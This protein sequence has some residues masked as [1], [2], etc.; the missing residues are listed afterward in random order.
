MPSEKDHLQKAERNS[1]F[2]EHL[3]A[4]CPEYLEWIVVA[5]FYT[6]LHY[7]DAFLATKGVHP[8]DHAMRDLQV[9]T[10]LRQHYPIYRALKNDSV[11]ARYDTLSFNDSDVR[12]NKDRL[13]DIIKGTKTA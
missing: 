4:N 8:G 6:A 11:D 12:K 13:A 1:R 10:Y 5:I 2:F 7:V 9:K 3:I